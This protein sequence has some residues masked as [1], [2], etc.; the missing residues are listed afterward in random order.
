MFH[1]GSVKHLESSVPIGKTEVI[2]PP[3][4]KSGASL[5]RDLIKKGTAFRPTPLLF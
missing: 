5:N 2:P 4:S 1:T 3:E